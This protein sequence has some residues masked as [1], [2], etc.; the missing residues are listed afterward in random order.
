MLRV[1]LKLAIAALCAA[2]LLAP[3][4]V[5]GDDT[6][7]GTEGV[8]A[9]WMSPKEKEAFDLLQKGKPV[10]A[11]RVA[12]A[13]LVEQPES[14]I[15]HY[16]LGRVL[17]E[18]EGALSR[19][20]FHL[21]HAR[22]LYE[23]RFPVS[24]DP[25]T[26]PWK[27]HRDLLLSVS[28][29][30]GEMEEYQ[31]QLEMLQF[32]D[33]L[34]R[35]AR[36]GE[37]AWPLMKLGRWQE[38]RAQ[39]EKAK[40]M[41]DPGQRSFGLNA[42]CAIERASHDRAAARAACA[43]AFDNAVAIEATLPEIDP[44]HRSSL[45]VHAYN[46]A[47][48]ARADFAAEEAEK[49]ALA[50]T[51][52][53]AFTPANPWRFLVNLYVDGGRGG[54]AA[55]ALREMHRWRMRQP[56]Q[57][58][59]QDRAENDV[60]VATVLLLAGRTEAALRL[61]DRAIEFPD[62]RGLSSTNEWQARAA[63]VLVRGAIRRA[64]VEILEEAASA[65]DESGP[66]LG[67]GARERLRQWADDEMVSGVLHDDDRLVDTFRLFGERGITPVPV[68]LLGDLV[69]VVGPGV[70]AV[71]LRM[72]REREKQPKLEPYW[73]AIEAEVHLARGRTGDARRLAELALGALP[74]TEALLRARAAAVAAMAARED[75]DRNAELGFLGRAYTID[76]SII[77]RMGLSLP[78]RF[79][80]S[81][82][83]SGQVIAMLRRSPR[84]R[85]S[86]GGFQIDVSASPGDYRICLRSPEGNELRCAPDAAGA[87]PPPAPPPPKPGEK[88]EPPEPM[89]AVKA[90]E[91]FHR[92]AFAMPL[93]LT[94]E[95]MNSLDGSTTVA[96]QAVR[97]RVD[98]ML[99][100]VTE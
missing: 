72:V 86:E 62:R 49:L 67:A 51:K 44:E 97:D 18:A 93:G 70:M 16:V 95:D 13:V 54:D 85:S 94:G 26:A 61:V 43:A 31:Y 19:A 74:E 5:R 7:G 79:A 40:G 12:E 28:S 60:S 73:Q 68:W 59:D 4:L 32:H 14:I 3:M 45:A 17:H 20:I 23:V 21:G 10:T 38:A 9:A 41:K 100:E 75:G 71:V 63:N 91:E 29:L 82:P 6:G 48:A 39:A 80:G 88:V 2:G 53:L 36:P 90:V 37:H 35:P 24:G 89:T 77:R 42:L 1:R 92:Q 66:G 87:T 55:T 99:G 64:H 30:A 11:R 56:P 46:A 81:G 34:Y 65:R 27:F 84:F 47:L 58:R 83:E 96:E 52:K 98:K 25:A 50:G 76:P 69:D 15:G 22:E 8:S 57:L 33:V 78:A